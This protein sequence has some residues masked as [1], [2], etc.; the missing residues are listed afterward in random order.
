MMKYMK[1]KN[2]DNWS[3]FV[4]PVL[5]AHNNSPHLLTKIASNKLNKDNEM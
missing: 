5:D 2:T 4:N 3:K 1:L